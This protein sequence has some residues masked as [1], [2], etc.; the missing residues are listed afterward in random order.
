MVP[1]DEETPSAPESPALARLINSLRGLLYRAEVDRAVIFALLTQVW[2]LLAGPVTLLLIAH[3]FT[4]ELQGFYYTFASLLALQS[5]V[6]LGFYLVIINVASHEW[7]HL[8]LDSDRRIVGEP[9]SL[10]RLVSLGRLIFKW[11][12]VASAIFV[13]GVSIV[14]FGFFSRDQKS[15]ILWQQPWLAI[16]L[17]TGLLLW[18]LPF[19]SLLEGCNQVAKI[20]Q[21]RLVQAMLANLSLWPTIVLGGGLWAAVAYSGTRLLCNLYLLLI[22]Y[23]RFFVP[24]FTHPAGPRI[25]WRTEILP[26]QW[27]L[28]LSGLV[29][30]FAFSLFNPVMFHYH[31]AAVAGQIGMTW[32]VVSTVQTVALAWVHTK[33]PRFGMLIARKDYAGLDRFWL[34][35]SLVSLA[36]VSGGA[37]AVWLLVYGLNALHVPLAQRLLA[38]SPTGLLLLA[39]ILM[40]VSQCQSAYLRAHKR[41]PIMV[42]SV[43]SS[44]VIGLL[45]WLLGSRFGPLGAAAGYLA[46]VAGYIIP[47]ETAIWFRCRAKWHKP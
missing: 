12:A 27:R 16:V 25:R 41:E 37:G 15:D 44:L 18:T 11:Y 10:S 19:N 47:Y 13:V 42:M 40:Q 26:M 17:L 32:Q 20:N 5:F 35:T 1:Q 23:R 8:G 30:Y 21:F 36:V 4:P 14:G 43:T 46:V 45:V 2:Q 3:Y 9:A 39:A 29:N 28:G 33:V 24:F 22:H 34:R 7:G 6:E 31:G 38:L